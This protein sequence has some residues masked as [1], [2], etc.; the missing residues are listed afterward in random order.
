MKNS[1]LRTRGRCIVA[2]LAC[3][4]MLA[5]VLI[6]AA[7]PAGAGA[8]VVVPQSIVLVSDINPGTASSSP[9]TITAVGSTAFF[10]ATDGT[11]VGGH[12]VELW[13][14][15]GTAAGTVLVK[16][17]NAVGTGSSNPASL[18]N[19]NGTLFFAATD[20]VN[21]I[22]LWKSDGT[23][24]GTVMVKDIN[25]TSSTASSSPAN[26]T[27]AG[28]TLF[29]TATNG[30]SGTEL[31]K[32]DGTAD[33]TVLVKD[34]NVGSGLS[35][36]AQ[37][38]NV[39]GTVWFRATDGTTP[40]VGHGIEPWKS[41]GTEAG[42]VLVKDINVGTASSSP[43]DFIEFNGFVYF[44]ASDGTV[45]PSHGNEI[46]RSD[47][48]EAGTTL[49]ID[50]NPGTGNSGVGP[51]RILN[52]EL[53][54]PGFTPATGTE[55]LKSDGTA[56]GTMV[57][58]EV[59]PGTTGGT[60][61]NFGL[62]TTTNLVYF[63]AVATG[64]GQELWR[65]DGTAAG[66]F[67]T[68]DIVPGSG[69][70]ILANFTNAELNGEFYFNGGGFDRE[71]W[72][73]DGTTAGTVL[74]HD[75]VPGTAG[76]F[77]SGMVV[78]NGTLFLQ[79]STPATGSELF[80]LNNGPTAVDDSYTTDEDTP[81]SVTAPG[82]LA[83][84]TDPDGNLNTL[85]AAKVTDPAHGTVT[86]NAD[87][88]FSYT[89]AA[90]YNGPDSFTYKAN[91]GSLDSTPVTVNITVT[92]AA[93]A[94]EAVDDTY[95]TP[96]DAPLTVNA[97]GV[98]GND[99][100]GDGDTLTAGSASTPA[101]GSVVL[102]SDG[103]F[104]YAPNAGYTGADS[105]TYVVSDGLGGTDTGTVNIGVTVPTISASPS[106]VTAGDAV[107]ATWA[108][109]PNPTATD[110]VGLYD[111]SSALDPALLAWSFTNGSGSGNL[112]LTV[113]LNAAAGDN[114]ELRLYSN[115]TYTRLA[116]SAPFTVSASA[117]TIAASP[118]SVSTGGLVTATWSGIASPTA[119]DWVGL[120]DSASAPEPALLAWT[121]TG[122]AAAGNLNLSVPA[123]A[124][125]G[126]AYELRLFSN[127]TYTRLATSAP[128]EVT[129]ANTT[130]S[131]SPASVNAGSPVT[132]TWSGIPA[133][134]ATDWIGVYDSSSDPDTAPVSWTFTDGNATGNLNLTVPITAASGA[135]Y[136]LR[137]F[138]N[139]SYVRLATSNAFS[140][141]ASTA[142][143][144]SSHSTVANGNPITATWS[145]IAA[146]SATDW[147]GLYDSSSAADSAIV[148]WAYTG[149]G[150]AGSLNL[151]VPAGSPPGATYEL[152]LYSDN[153][154]TR[155]AT[156]AP[157]TVT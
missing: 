82:L 96:K 13:K 46:W 17:I 2:T 79:D 147:V 90:N 104:T 66:T 5:G 76:S 116:T 136:E 140:V 52:G 67:M 4:A 129:A 47:G 50:L 69:N 32:S 105:F 106:S 49:F 137:L 108:N 132:A 59:V 74:V 65:T 149:G 37:L 91:D 57:V 56:A 101:N 8:A 93:D 98:L 95:S 1:G 102:N 20:G 139:N 133:P 144:S 127:N 72:K 51:F 114:Y 6:G 15:N 156:S 143:I 111:S 118:S 35:S 12:G 92:A 48:T 89:P 27:V 88:S 154:Y 53:L 124:T 71:V 94:P 78:I 7:T 84:D 41:D 142:T 153:T 148:A 125:P 131:A 23:A 75:L 36:P 113:P 85:T 119:G 150:A 16:D 18:V 22:E 33:G 77:P 11:G 9:T 29:F 54:F 14:S 70:G 135:A 120:Y 39:N 55:L 40:G 42:T 80:R 151:T 126:S 128:F 87:G 73:T 86:V 138:S 99:I 68:K 155:L 109:V 112:D 81:L 25:T 24:D 134:S 44:T 110:W 146:P 63:M 152:R 122:G 123:G 10:R 83:N 34:I 45:A 62:P 21:G 145:G 103:S 38:T 117:T 3:S 60:I 28:S 26:L 130:L 157:F 31:F 141:T 43:F 19:F 58:A 97:P 64:T 30:T 107:T 115:N 61:Q 100:D 121:Y